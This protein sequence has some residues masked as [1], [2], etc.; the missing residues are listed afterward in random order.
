MSDTDLRV[1]IETVRVE[2]IARFPAASFGMMFAERDQFKT[3]P[4]IHLTR[5]LASGVSV[6]EAAPTLYQR[7]TGIPLPSDT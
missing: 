5:I 4:K 1:M 6:N 3:E 7:M 2:A